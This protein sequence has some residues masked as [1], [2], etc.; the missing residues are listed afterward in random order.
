M[1]FRILL[2]SC[3]RNITQDKLDAE[4]SLKLILKNVFFNLFLFL[5]V[6]GVH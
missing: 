5:A 6:L 2:S 4:A 1:G 3:N